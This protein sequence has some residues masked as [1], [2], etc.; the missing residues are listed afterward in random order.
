MV[1]VVVP[2]SPLPQNSLTPP[3]FSFNTPMPSQN[4]SR[5]GGWATYE[6]QRAPAALELL[7][8]SE[9]FGKIMVDYEHVECRYAGGGG[10]GGG[11]SQFGSDGE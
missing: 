1:V 5:G 7:N 4:R 10:K 2:P 6:L 11:G 9:V 8:P 3:H